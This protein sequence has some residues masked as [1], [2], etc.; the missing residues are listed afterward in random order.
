M[1]Y[2]A[3]QHNQESCRQKAKKEVTISPITLPYMLGLYLS[4]HNYLTRNTCKQQTLAHSSN[5]SLENPSNVDNFSK[6]S[7]RQ[8]VFIIT[9]R[10][11]AI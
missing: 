11:N 2:Q 10:G 5:I 6:L 3:Y 8:I 7:K 1:Q 4:W 9:T